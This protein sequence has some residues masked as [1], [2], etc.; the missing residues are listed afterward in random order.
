M[1]H[2]GT[3]SLSTHLMRAD[4]A[5]GRVTPPIETEMEE[6]GEVQPPKEVRNSVR[7]VE[8]SRPSYYA[9]STLGDLLGLSSQEVTFQ[10][11]QSH[12]QKHTISPACM[13]CYAFRVS[14]CLLML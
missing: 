12:I 13:Q 14:L 10:D 5:V 9:V 3:I 2:F 1:F 4:C 11:L 8:K 6:N 7:T